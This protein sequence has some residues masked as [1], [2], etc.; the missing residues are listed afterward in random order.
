MQVQARVAFAV[1]LLW[2]IVAPPGLLGNKAAL[3]S[4]NWEHEFHAVMPLG[5]DLFL[6]DS[7]KGSVVLMATAVT[8][9]LEGWKRVNYGG[10]RF[11][12]TP[13]G[14]RPQIYPRQAQ[15]RVT[16]S[17]VDIVPA[18]ADSLTVKSPTPLN[19]FLLGL[20]FRIKIFHGLHVRVVRPDDIHM[21]G[22]PA[23]VRY[24]ERIYRVS[25]RLPPVPVQDRMVL[26]VLSPDGAR[27]AR[28]HFEL[29]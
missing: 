2:L 6:L 4:P 5:S 3:S 17:A 26:E 22:V 10:S 27:L 7:Q 16:A 13:D 23:D 18:N 11:L 21:I 25:F 15:F 28:F 19:D 24:K 12:Y 29:M 9:E 8:P 14:R 1:T 20:Q